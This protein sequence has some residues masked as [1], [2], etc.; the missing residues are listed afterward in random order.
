MAYAFLINLFW[1]FKYTGMDKDHK[2][3]SC[4]R[5]AFVLRWLTLDEETTVTI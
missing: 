2:S 3:S 1:I 5:I 4:V